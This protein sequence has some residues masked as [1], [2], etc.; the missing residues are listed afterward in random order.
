[1]TDNDPYLYS[2]TAVLRNKLGILAAAQLDVVEREIVTQRARYGV[3]Q[4]RFDLKH[5][6]AIHR[7]L[8]QDIH[9]WAGNIRTVELAKGGARF[10]FVR[11]IETGMHD[12]HRRLTASHFLRKLTAAEFAASAGVII[13]D[14]NHVHPF[15]EGNGRAQLLYLEQLAEQAGHHFDIIR[16]DPRRW[17]EASRAANRGNYGAMAAEIGLAIQPARGGR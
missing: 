4:G 11:F 16:L 6:R 12:V 8:F 3:P 15:R 5:L 7:H 2:G 17:M 14:V 1:M 10:Q 13:G 9:D